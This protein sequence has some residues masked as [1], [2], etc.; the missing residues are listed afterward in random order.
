MEIRKIFASIHLSYTN[1][2]FIRFAQKF[3]DE[4]K[5]IPLILT[6]IRLSIHQFLIYQISLKKKV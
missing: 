2:F 4:E 5:K 3:L 1:I 6:S